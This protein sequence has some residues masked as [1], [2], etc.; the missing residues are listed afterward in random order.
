MS[1]EL[2]WKI[3]LVGSLALFACMS[4]WVSIGGAF[5]VRKLLRRLEHLDELEHSE[6]DA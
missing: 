3:C 6:D 2:L 5:E 4:I 1:W